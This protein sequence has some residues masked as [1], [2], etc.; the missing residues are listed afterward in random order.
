VGGEE[1]DDEVAKESSGER[2]PLVIGFS[3]VASG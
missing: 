2:E 1:P 3:F